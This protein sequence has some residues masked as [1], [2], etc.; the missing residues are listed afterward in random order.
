[1]PMWCME[2][3]KMNEGNSLGQGYSRPTGCSAEKVPHATFLFPWPKRSSASPVQN[4]SG[5]LS[6]LDH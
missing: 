4:L 3:L 6:V 2:P 5:R 1:M